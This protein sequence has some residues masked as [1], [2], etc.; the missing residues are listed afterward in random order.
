MWKDDDD[1][2][3]DLV[4]N[5]DKKKK[6]RFPLICPICRKREGHLYFHRN[7]VNENKG[8]LWTW[9]SACH[10]SAHAEFL[11]PEWW[12]NLAQLDIGKLA[13]YPDYLEEHKSNIDEWINH[14]IL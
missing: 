5:L 7:K 2:I 4:D 10:H 6:E 3:M 9:C 8:S 1:K 12:E 14:L 13:S 11:I